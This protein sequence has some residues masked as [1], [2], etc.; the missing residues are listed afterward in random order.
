MATENPQAFSREAFIFFG[1]VGSIMTSITLKQNVKHIFIDG[2]RRKEKQKES[3]IL[4]S[5]K[6][7]KL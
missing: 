5:I 6:K 4:K 1:R 7:I 3:E 2:H